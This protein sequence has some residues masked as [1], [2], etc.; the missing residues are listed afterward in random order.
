MTRLLC[1]PG[2]LCDERLW[3]EMRFPGN[4]I[5]ADLTRDD[6]IVAM[7]TRALADAP[8]R[9]VAV[10]LSMGGIVAFQI[11]R[12]APERLVGMILLDTNPAADTD[13][14]RVMR[15]RQEEAVRAGQLPQIVAE[16]LK[17]NY[18]AAAN[19]TDA[20]LLGLTLAMAVGLGPDVFLR[21]SAALRTRP[22]AWSVL[23]GITFPVL[24]ACGAEDR[25]CP[26]DLH[27]RMADAMPDA[28]LEIVDGAGHLTPLE[29]PEA[30]NLAVERWIERNIVGELA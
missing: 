17:P 6:D 26:P 1:L 24:I 9:F 13:D 2:L 30:L 5:H 19:R 7:A 15:L 10:G 12:L 4:V 22:D 21:Q 20:D 18:L 16:E 14:K 23:P 3:R 8:E 11:A 28:M 27:R 25:L 29:Q